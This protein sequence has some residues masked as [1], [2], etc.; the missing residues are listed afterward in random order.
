MIAERDGNDVSAV[1]LT[2]SEPIDEAI[3]SLERQ[4]RP[5][6]E[7]H[8]VRGITPFHRALNEGASRVTTRFFVQVDADMTLDPGCLAELRRNARRRVGIVVAQLRDALIGRVVGVKLFRTACFD[9]AAMPDTISPDTDFGHA[10]AEAGWRTVYVG[11]PSDERSDAWTT[12]GEHRPDYSPA[13]TYRKYLLEGRR[14]VHRA[15]HAGIRWHFQRL[16]SSTHPMRALAQVGLAQGLFLG[17]GRDLLAPLEED[18]DVSRILA[19]L[20]TG[21][22]ADAVPDRDDTLEQVFRSHRRLG[23]RIA[24]TS[25]GGSFGRLFDALPATRRDDGAW[26]AK[27]A[28]CRGLVVGS[29][30]QE[31]ADWYALDALMAAPPAP[32]PAPGPRGWLHALCGRL[33]LPQR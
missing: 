7:I 22:T 6:R 10:I 30:A 12:W 14:Y 24:T 18:G 27:V 13:Y 16:E 26:V 1:V 17:T 3:A 23:V 5:P 9:L 8:V 20:A 4:T 32:L 11:R 19:F 29:D 28:L 33:R 15:N 21:S 31:D 25:D 2:V